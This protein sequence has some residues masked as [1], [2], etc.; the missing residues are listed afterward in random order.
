MSQEHPQL[1]A[2]S[3]CGMVSW[4]A[5]LPLRGAEGRGSCW[6]ERGLGTVVLCPVSA[7]GWQGSAEKGSASCGL[8]EHS[9]EESAFVGVEV[10]S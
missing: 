4:G 5:F 8:W 7:R 9:R 1:R 3:C 10:M 6:D 2:G